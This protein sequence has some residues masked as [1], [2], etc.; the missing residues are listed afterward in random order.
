MSANK[1]T[2]A[3]SEAISQAQKERLAYLEMRLWFAGELRRPDIES[4]FG[5]RPAAASRDLT[6]YRELAPRNLEYDPTARCYRPTTSFKPVFGFS[7]DRV[8]SWLAAGFG[9]GLDPRPKKAATCEGLTSLCNPDLD[10]LASVSRALCTRRV[11]KITYLSVSSGKASR[12]IVPVALADTGLR[13]HVRAYD[14]QNARFSDFALRRIV[15][16]EI[17]DAKVED[18][19]LIEADEQW[20]R[21]VDLELVPHPDARWPQGIEADFGMQD[22][23]LRIKARAALVGYVLRRWSVDAS[24]DHRLDPSSHHLWLR[25]TPTLYGVESA[26]FA[27]GTESYD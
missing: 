1:K 13:W 12:L 10:I 5:V 17:L 24:P 4:R 9:D 2:T 27:P 25:N 3:V 21:I 11:L 22:G 8:L 6:A 16:A 23:L 20:A 19:E 7:A 26:A 14:R 18:V 15:K